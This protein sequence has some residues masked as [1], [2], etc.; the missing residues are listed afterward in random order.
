[1]FFIGMAHATR[2]LVRSNYY[3]MALAFVAIVPSSASEIQHTDDS[4]GLVGATPILCYSV[5]LG[6]LRYK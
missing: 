6:A 2:W 5:C 3:I 1:M 4:F